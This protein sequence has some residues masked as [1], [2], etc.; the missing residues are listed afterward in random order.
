MTFYHKI[1]CK[2]SSNYL[3]YLFQK[4]Y[5]TLLN[6]IILRKILIPRRLHSTNY[7]NFLIHLTAEYRILN[8]TIQ[9]G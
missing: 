9:P 2:Y 6:L 7:R 5:E 4:L 8:V 1:F 3:P